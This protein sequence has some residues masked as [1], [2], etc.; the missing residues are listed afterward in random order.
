MLQSSFQIS[1]RS[2]KVHNHIHKPFVNN[3]FDWLLL[4]QEPIRG[5]VY[6]PVNEFQHEV[7]NFATKLGTKFQTGLQHLGKSCG[8]DCNEF[9]P[10]VQLHLSRLHLQFLLRFLVRFSLLMHVNE[11][12]N[13]ERSG[14]TVCTII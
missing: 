13:C 9:F 11:Q 14:Y 1:L 6:N 4:V 2:S 5:F 12:M 3:A 7:L 10:Y 8:I